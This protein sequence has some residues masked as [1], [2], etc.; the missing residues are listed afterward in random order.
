MQIA[1]AVLGL[2]L[3][4]LAPAQDAAPAELGAFA[5][6]ETGPRMSR[7][8]TPPA[9][10]AA[11]GTEPPAP[12][13]ILI[14]GSAGTRGEGSLEFLLRWQGERLAL[15]L[16]A[17]GSAGPLAPARQGVIA[18]A[19][20]SIAPATLRAELRARP[21]QAG[22]ARLAGEVGLR[23]EGGPGSVDLAVRAISARATAPAF[24]RVHAQTGAGAAAEL[25]AFVA[26]LEAQVPVREALL[27]GLR[28]A[29]AA[30]EL[31]WRGRA[32]ARPWEMV[33]SAILEWPDRWEALASLR[34]QAGDFAIALAAGG[35]VPAVPG[36]V[37]ARAS[38]R[39]EMQAGPAT[40]SLSVGAAHHW[41]YDLWLGE[42]GFAAAFRLGGEGAHR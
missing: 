23:A 30:N 27:L 4:V 2:L 13:E 42:L 38:L 7:S 19:E 8:E 34:A 35:G 37:A 28:L 33:G 15:G 32:P 26:A 39:T 3:S 21:P 31:R 25:T 36:A 14:E 17:E 1:L 24:S 22:A 5:V 18:Q 12:V 9:V 40:L 11:A 41:P 20:V 16:G 29:A 6:S 10:P